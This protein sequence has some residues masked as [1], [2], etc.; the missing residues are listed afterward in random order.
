MR[1]RGIALPSVDD[2]ARTDVVRSCAS[3]V[4]GDKRHKM[5]CQVRPSSLPVNS[6]DAMQILMT[7]P[8][9]PTAEGD[10]AG[11]DAS[12]TVPQ[13]RRKA[14]KK[15]KPYVRTDIAALCKAIV[16]SSG[17]RVTL[18]MLHRVAYLVRVVP[19]FTRDTDISSQ[20]YIL[21]YNDRSESF[22]DT[23]D[24]QLKAARNEL[25]QAHYERYV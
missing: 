22:W 24:G 1:A 10:G 5:K 9:V 12:D 4:F 11:D 18:D 13:P 25:S 6:S 14:P 21:E 19:R 15:D 16:G 20:R 3:A 8:P 7:L 2:L 23:V 17:V